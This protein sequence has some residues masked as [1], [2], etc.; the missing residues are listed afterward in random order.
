MVTGEQT[1][2]RKMNTAF[3]ITSALNTKFGVY[4]TTERIEQ[5]LA[6]AAS[7]RTKVPGATIIAVEMAGV[8][9]TPEQIKIMEE[10]VDEYIILSNDADV[11]AI[12]HSTDNWDIVKNTTEVLCFSRALTQLRDRLSTFDRVFKISGRYTLSDDF[13]LDKFADTSKIVVAKRRGTQFGAQVTGGIVEQYMSR[14]WTWPGSM[15]DDVIKAYTD[16]FLFIAQQIGRGGYCDIEH[17]LFKFLPADRLIEVDRV[18][19]QGN[20]APN[21]MAI[22]D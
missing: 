1:M 4:K 13:S 10:A 3:M 6:T 8:P 5:T 21:G 15:T 11:Q 19:I 18:G 22:V 17:M 12:Y 7:I 9:P 16:G 14:L 2:A 20:I